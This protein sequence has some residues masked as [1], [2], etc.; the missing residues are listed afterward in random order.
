M[1][2][3]AAISRHAQQQVAGRHPARLGR[4]G[5]GRERRVE[6]VDVDRQEHRPAPDRRDRVGD[7]GADAA[8]ADVV[9][10][11]GDDPVPLLPGELLGAGPVAAQA[12]LHV[13]RRV[14]VA[15]LDEP[16]HRAAVRERHAERLA[17]GVR[18]GVE[19]DEADRA[20]DLGAGA[21]VRLGDRV[22]AAEDDRDRAGGE[23]LRHRV[24][25]RDVRADRV[26]REDRRVAEVDDPEGAERV[27]TR[28]QVRP[29]SAAGRADRPRAEARARRVGRQLVHRGADD[30]G[31]RALELGGVLGVGE[32]AEGQQAGVV[33]LLAVG[34]PA[35]HRIDHGFSSPRVR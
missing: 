21:D 15:G 16:V 31:V 14:D 8:V 30:R 11:V 12:D 33:G 26:G 32:A 9:H 24:L 5:A 17:R 6:H 20:V 27:D 2:R 7:D 29:G 18:V 4:P 10:E 13:A 28:L 22:V 34:G 19:V 25:D 1:S 3:P 23:D 35:A